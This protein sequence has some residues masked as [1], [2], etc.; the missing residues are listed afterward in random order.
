MFRLL[1]LQLPLSIILSIGSLPVRCDSRLQAEETRETQSQRVEEEMVS[2]HPMNRFDP[3]G[4]ARSTCSV[5]LICPG[6]HRS[7]QV[8]SFDSPRGAR[9]TMG[10]GLALRI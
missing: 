4:A 1:L 8:Q 6:Q 7:R 9:L 3:R 2:A 5:P 10:P